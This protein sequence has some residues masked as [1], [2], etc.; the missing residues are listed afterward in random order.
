MPEN[1]DLNG[2]KLNIFNGIFIFLKT[3]YRIIKHGERTARNYA[4]LAD[5]YSMFER[6]KIGLYYALKAVRADRKYIPAYTIAGGC[7]LCFDDKLHLAEKYLKKAIQLSEDNGYLPLYLLYTCYIAQ[8]NYVQMYNTGLKFLGLKIKNSEYYA[9][10][11]YV[12]SCF[13]GY[14]AEYKKELQETVLN[15]LKTFTLPKYS[16]IFS[17]LV[18]FILIGYSIYSY[19]FQGNSGSL[20]INGLYDDGEYDICLALLNK[21]ILTVKKKNKLMLSVLYPYKASC[22]MYKTN[23]EYEKAMESLE[24]YKQFCKKKDMKDYYYLKA[25][26]AYMADDY[27]NALKYSNEALLH[28]IEARTLLIKGYTCFKLDM[29]EE[30]EKT[31]LKALTYKNC[32]KFEAYENLSGVLYLR[33]KYE[34]ALKYINKALI[35]NQTSTLYYGKSLILEKLGRIPESEKYYA[36]YKELE[37]NKDIYK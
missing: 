34:D 3:K 30:A 17:I 12:I 31:Y 9:F 5:F 1:K 15:Y 11:C 4:I 22:Q 26:F 6:N 8:E 28:K 18:S 33:E 16:E 19:R 13:Y 14:G 21:I 35:I 10:A 32:D 27:S 20:L 29:Y 7:Y 25:N 36:K 37:K 2:F 24:K 23:P